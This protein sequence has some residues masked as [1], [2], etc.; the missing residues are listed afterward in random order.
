MKKKLFI[1]VPIILIAILL[2][3]I[4]LPKESHTEKVAEDFLKIYYSFSES[5]MIEVKSPSDNEKLA[6]KLQQDY[7][8][9]AWD[10]CIESLIKNRYYKQIQDIYSKENGNIIYQQA[11]LEV[12]DKGESGEN[13]KNYNYEC[14]FKVNNVDFTAK[15]QLSLKKQN[16]WKVKDFI[17]ISIKKNG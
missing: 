7:Q 6:K 15:G 8:E 14:V 17:I 11:T 13:V 16:E 9:V 3:V 1:I 4:F 2:I 5:N 10:T 12:L